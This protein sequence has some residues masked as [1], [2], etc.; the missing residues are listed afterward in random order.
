MGYSS[1]GRAAVSETVWTGSIPVAPAKLGEIVEGFT[2]IPEFPEYLITESGKVFSTKSNRLLTHQINSSGY[3]Y[4]TFTYKYKR[5][6]FLVHRLLARVFKD[7][8]SLDSDLEVDHDNR[9]KLDFS[10]GNL[11][12]RSSVEHRT[13]TTE[14]RGHLLGGSRC[15]TCDVPIGSGRSYCLTHYKETLPHQE[16]T[17]EDIE[18]WVLNFSWTRAAKELGLSDNGLRKRYKSLT[19]KDPKTIKFA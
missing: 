10:L 16:I 9:N 13:K 7:L 11:I 19:G 18:Y 4:V 3:P 8:P 17:P 1:V 6:S 5:H 15:R 12:V 14:E 2:V